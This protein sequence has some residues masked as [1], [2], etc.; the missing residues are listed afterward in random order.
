[1][2]I[3]VTVLCG[4]LSFKDFMYQYIQYTL[5]DTQGFFNK[6]LLNKFTHI[7]T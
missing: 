5:S 1:M 6:S 3:S 7:K 4:E 2:H